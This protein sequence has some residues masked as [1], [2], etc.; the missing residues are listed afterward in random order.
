[1]FSLLGRVYPGFLLHC[2]ITFHAGQGL[3]PLRLVWSLTLAPEFLIHRGLFFP[4]V[5]SD[6]FFYKFSWF[7]H[8]TSILAL[9]NVSF[10]KI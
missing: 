10:P 7:L 2:L 6:T 1:M 4:L 5:V 9:H 3:F 8:S